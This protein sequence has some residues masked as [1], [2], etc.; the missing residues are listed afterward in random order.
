[1]DQKVIEAAITK[2][3]RKSYVKTEEYRQQRTRDFVGF[4]HRPSRLE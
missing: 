3:A 2:V 1:M 4:P